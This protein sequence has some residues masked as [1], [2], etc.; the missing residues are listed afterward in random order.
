[1][2]KLLDVTV[3]TKYPYRYSC[4]EIGSYFFRR[5]RDEKRIFGR[6]CPKC[7]KV[8]IPPRPVC[9]PCWSPTREWVEVGPAGTLEAFTVV[10]FTFLDPMTGKSRPVPYGYGLVK[11][12]GCDSR[13]QHF[14]SESDPKKLKVGLRMVPE[15]E[16]ER[17]GRLSDIKWFRPLG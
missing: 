5:L 14:L 13:L 7:G 3:E 11:L 15:F 9:G 2:S 12:D 4:G 6:K 8:Y 16:E 10:Y 17:K 1:M